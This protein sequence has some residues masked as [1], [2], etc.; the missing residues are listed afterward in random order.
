MIPR[1]FGV[2]DARPDFGR[3]TAFGSS[4]LSSVRGILAIEPFM[5]IALLLG[6]IAVTFLL[7]AHE[8]HAPATGLIGV[9]DAWAVLVLAVT[10]VAQWM[11]HAV[12]YEGV[13]SL[14][15][16]ALIAACLLSFAVAWKDLRQHLA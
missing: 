15:T 12:L 2:L 13:A 3:A 9:A 8:S 10:S 14:V 11:W 5:L 6:A 7:T 16:G 1:C 4:Q